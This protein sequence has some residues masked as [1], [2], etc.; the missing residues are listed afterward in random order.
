MPLAARRCRAALPLTLLLA[1]ALLP[2]GCDSSCSFEP[3]GCYKDQG[4]PRTLRWHLDGCPT[5]AEFHRVR[6][7]LVGPEPPM[8]GWGWARSLFRSWCH[9]HDF[10]DAGIGIISVR[11]KPVEQGSSEPGPRKEVGE[12][13]V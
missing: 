10:H 6:P 3:V 2:S 4:S 8:L 12:E 7:R 11:P 13:E 1:L 9:E 5:A